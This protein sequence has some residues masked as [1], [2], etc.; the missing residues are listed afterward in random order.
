VNDWIVR[1]RTQVLRI[2]IHARHFSSCIC[3]HRH[4]HHRRC[5]CCQNEVQFL[6]QRERSCERL[7]DVIFDWQQ[8]Q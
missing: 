5:F 1:E 7:E 4:R 2:Q 3:C 6:T 8:Q